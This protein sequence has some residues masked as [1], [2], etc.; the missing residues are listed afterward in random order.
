MAKRSTRKTTK[1]TSSNADFQPGKMGLAVAAAAAVS[2]TL[3]AVV[4]MYL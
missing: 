1:K 4:A 3:F 2:L